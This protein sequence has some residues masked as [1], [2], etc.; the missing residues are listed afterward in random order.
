[1]A[2]QLL[3]N[4]KAT[5]DGLLNFSRGISIPTEVKVAGINLSNT[6]I[7]FYEGIREPGLSFSTLEGSK[8]AQPLSSQ[9]SVLPAHQPVEKGPAFPTPRVVRQDIQSI[10][11]LIFTVHQQRQQLAESIRQRKTTLRIS[12]L[13]L[14]ASH[15][16]LV[17][18]VKKSVAVSLKEAIQAQQQTLDTLNEQLTNSAVQLNVDF[19][20]PIKANYE[21]LV[22]AYRNLTRSEKVWSVRGAFQENNSSVRSADS[23]DMQRREVQIGYKSLPVIKFDQQAFYFHN[24]DKTHLYFYPNFII[25][26]N[27]HGPFTVVGYNE[28]SFRFSATCFTE[29]GTVPGD[30]QVVGQAFANGSLNKS[31]QGNSSRPIVQ[32]GEIEFTTHAGLREAFQFSHYKYCQ[33]FASAFHDYLKT[34]VSLSGKPSE[35]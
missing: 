6:G 35:N 15:T 29:V 10:K 17:A 20:G 2:W 32:Y 3:K 12:K 23:G 30:S 9:N 26:D 31:L 4:G 24:A 14:T 34:I 8:T 27:G 11:E 25:V 13:K 7:S 1:M 19:D 5:F 33:E 18:L 28:L 16:F 21:R 22:K